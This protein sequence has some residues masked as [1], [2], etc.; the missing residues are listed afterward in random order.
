MDKK[1]QQNLMHTSKPQKSSTF[2]QP[3]TQASPRPEVVRVA[4][5]AIEKLQA[6]LEYLKDK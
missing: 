6:D 5:K 1:K 3:D 4:R 2:E